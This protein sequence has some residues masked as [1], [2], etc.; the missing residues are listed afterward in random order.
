MLL[1]LADWYLHIVVFAFGAAIG[2]FINLCST[3]IPLGQNIAYPTSYADCCNVN[4]KWYQNIP[5]LSYLFLGGRCGNCKE[6]IAWQ[7]P[8]VELACAGFA[9]ASLEVWGL[10]VTGATHFVLLGTLVLITC[11]DLAH[12]IIPN[13][14]TFPGIVIGIVLA[15]LGILPLT[16]LESLSGAVAG[17]GVLWLIAAI[18]HKVRKIEGLGGGD[19]KLMAMLGAFMGIKGVVFI[20]FFSSVFGALVGLYLIAFFKKGKE[21]PIPF[22]PFIAIAAVA[23]LFVGNEIWIWYLETWLYR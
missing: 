3:R 22:G 18:Y 11:I 14:I 5:I 6:R 15:A 2:S 19:I 16:L 13:V 10:S 4:L 12:Y 21:Y 8:F 7:Y 23:Y 1:W 20:L 9:V 17:G